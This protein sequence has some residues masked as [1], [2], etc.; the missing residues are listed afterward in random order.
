MAC[1]WGSKVNGILTV[2]AVGIAV[3]VDLW[4]ILDVKKNP[5]IVCL[6][7]ACGPLDSNSITGIFL[8]AL[9]GSCDR[10]YRHS[11]HSVPFFLLDSFRDPHQ[12]RTG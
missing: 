7:F 10:L 11:F 12:V 9:H 4:D 1:T 8:E 6:S 2:V 3:L 5:N